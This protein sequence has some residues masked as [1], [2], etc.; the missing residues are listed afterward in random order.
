MTSGIPA[1]QVLKGQVAEAVYSFVD[2][3]L[4]RFYVVQQGP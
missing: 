1:A 3:Q 4:P 2:A